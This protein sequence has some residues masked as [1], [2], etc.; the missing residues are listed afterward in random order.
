[1]KKLFCGYRD[2]SKRIYESLSEKHDLDFCESQSHLETLSPS[3]YSMVFFVGWSD[4]IG[5]EWVEE[6]ECICLH[7]SMLPKYRGGSPIQN[8]ILSGERWS[9]VTLFKMNNT[10][11]G[12]DI[13]CQKSFSLS[14]TLDEIFT[15]IE[16]LG[17]S[18]IDDLLSSDEIVYT[19][20]DD[21]EA[22]FCSRRTPQMSEI[23]PSDFLKLT[24]EQL[25][26]KIR[27][28]QE[29]YPLPYIVCKGGKKLFIKDV[30][31]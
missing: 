13:A 3:D 16:V 17:I 27:C 12:G 15:R 7:P 11:D 22:T 2:W 31:I 24:P 26:D 6:V 8:Q 4:I 19:P 20:Q 29:P 23:H 21:S 9:G 5:P 14:G 1:M 30:M 25:Y 10:L 18:M 28:L